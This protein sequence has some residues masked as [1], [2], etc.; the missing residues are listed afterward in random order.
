[1]LY[2]PPGRIA[3]RALLERRYKNRFAVAYEYL[4]LAVFSG[5]DEQPNDEQE[6]WDP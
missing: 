5:G 2:I 1:M 4:K 3:L 6:V